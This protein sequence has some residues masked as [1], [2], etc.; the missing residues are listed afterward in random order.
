MD[1]QA[2]K[3]ATRETCYTKKEGSFLPQPSP[4]ITPEFKR[5]WKEK[6][7]FFEMTPNCLD[8]PEKRN[9]YIKEILRAVLSVPGGFSSP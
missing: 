7:F 9:A 3:K 5:S 2:R 1:R 4:L 6:D 8:D